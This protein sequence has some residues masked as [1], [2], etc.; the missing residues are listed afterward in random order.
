MPWSRL[1][2]RDAGDP[3]PPV[4]F[5]QTLARVV[6]GL[7]APS[8]DVLVLVHERWSEVV[9]TEIASHARAVGISGNTLKVAAD[10]A[11]W[12]SHVRWSQAEIVASIEALT[13]RS[14]ITSLTVKVART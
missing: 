6:D 2:T 10:S 1:P 3:R 7:G 12:A 5:A 8:V 4:A 13:G 9:G 11:A 14:E